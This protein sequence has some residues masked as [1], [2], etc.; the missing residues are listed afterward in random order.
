VNLS[1]SSFVRP[2]WLS[3]SN[4]H[5]PSKARR[6]PNSCTFPVRL[7]MTGY[8]ARCLIGSHL[9]VQALKLAAQCRRDFVQILFKY[10]FPC[11]VVV[12]RRRYNVGGP[13]IW[14][15]ASPRY[16]PNPGFHLRESSPLTAAFPPR[17]RDRSGGGDGAP[18][19]LMN[20]APSAC[21]CR[22]HG[23]QVRQIATA[24]PAGAACCRARLGIEP[25]RPE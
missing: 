23:L 10:F 12:G 11:L 3:S 24:A 20:E 15:V 13:L 18:V 9:L 8:P 5:A 4:S 19:G 16:S 25:S 22:R 17:R 7:L 2:P 1:T 21:F 6:W 14:V